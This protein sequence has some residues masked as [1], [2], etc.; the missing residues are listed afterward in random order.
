VRLIDLRRT[1]F[2]SLDIQIPD[3]HVDVGDGDVMSV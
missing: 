2:L 1:G 3:P